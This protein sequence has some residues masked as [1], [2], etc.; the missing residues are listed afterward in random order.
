M[1][2]SSGFRRLANTTSS[3]KNASIQTPIAPGGETLPA[4]R[5]G[6]VMKQVSWKSFS[7][8]FGI[9]AFIATLVAVSCGKGS[10]VAGK[11]NGAWISSGGELFKDSNNPWFIRNT[12]EVRYCVQFDHAGISTSEETATRI[13][14]MA[15]DYWKAELGKF[16]KDQTGSANFPWLGIGIQDFVR[17][18][19]DGKQQL[20]FKFGFGTL[21]ENEILYLKN[22]L[23]Y[24]SLAV[25]TEYDRE[26]L[27]GRGF[28]FVAS[29]RGPN[30]YEGDTELIEEPWQHDGL[31][32]RI[33]IHEL[34]HVFGI[35]HIGD[36]IMSAQFPEH[37]LKKKYYEHYKKLS[38]AEV[39]EFFFLPEAF[40]NCQ[41][42]DEAKGWFKIPSDWKCLYF[43]ISEGSKTEPSSVKMPVNFYASQDLGTFIKPIGTGYTEKAEDFRMGFSRG[44]VLYLGTD[45]KVFS[46][47]EA[48]FMEYISGPFFL[49]FDF[50]LQYEASNGEKMPLYMK[51]RAGGH[52]LLVLK[53]KQIH[54]LIFHSKRCITAPFFYFCLSP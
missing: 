35:P 38:A 39:G 7:V 11:T 28:I 6:G 45:Q 15:I 2:E 27:R 12:P 21:D 49:A 40:A 30:R 1:S 16:Q 41:L 8:G 47:Q 54:S 13:L 50:A 26:N 46:E 44:I 33:L 23:Q 22:P 52:E 37:I 51:L 4:F 25:R 19:C 43:R 14:R 17:T 9:A 20:A 32:Y 42:T 24:A 31:L 29:D 48:K 18:D 36:G 10:T 5:L 3:V 34:G 53:E